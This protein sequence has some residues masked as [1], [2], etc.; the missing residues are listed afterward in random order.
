[1]PL[2][3]AVQARENDYGRDQAG[4]RGVEISCLSVM[5]G[6]LETRRDCGALFWRHFRRSLHHLGTNPGL[7]PRPKLAKGASTKRRRYANPEN[8]RLGQAAGHLRRPSD[9]I[10]S[11][12]LSVV[13]PV[14]LS[15]ARDFPARPILT[16]SRVQSICFHQMPVHSGTITL[17]PSRHV[18]AR[19]SPKKKRINSSASCGEANW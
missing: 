2:R 11:H 1:M 9:C 8:A 3:R 12:G 13:E 5:S 6:L 16:L 10:R 19:S 7:R 18:L 14:Q 17:L 4:N 15:C